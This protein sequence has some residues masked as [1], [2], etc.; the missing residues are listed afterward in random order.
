MKKKLTKKVVAITGGNSGIGLAIAH[1]AQKEGALVAIFGRSKATMQSALMSLNEG[2]LGVLGDVRNLS[3]IQNFISQVKLKL[4][5]IDAV[6][7]NA[8]EGIERDLDKVD[9][10]FFNAVNNINFRGA[11]FTA[12]KAIRTRATNVVIDIDYSL[13]YWVRSVKVA[14]AV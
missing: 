6:I 12:I 14:V 4:G 9:E 7:I 10:E 1:L 11:Y 3:E 13:P 2:T 5:P 8:G